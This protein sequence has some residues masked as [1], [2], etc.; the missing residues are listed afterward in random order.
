MKRFVN[1]IVQSTSAIIVCLLLLLSSCVDDMFIPNDN[2]VPE[3]YVRL[4]F[5][6]HVSDMKRV[7]TRSVDPDGVDIQSLTLFCFNPYGLFITTVD[8][9]IT[10]DGPTEG[11]FQADI[12]EETHII[13]F[14][15]NQNSNLF[16]NKDFLNKNEEAVMADME[17]ASGMLIYWA[18]IVKNGEQSFNDQISAMPKGVELIRNQAMIKIDDWTTPYFTV[19]GYVTTNIH[20]FGTV[21]PHHP[22]DGFVWPGNEPF[23]TLP[24]NPIMMSDIEDI[25]TKPEDYVFEHENTI[26]NPISVIIKGRNQGTYEDLYYR[27]SLIDSEGD[28]IMIRRNHAYTLHITGKLS[29][30]SKTFEEALSAPFSNNIWI[31]IDSWVT[32]IEDEKYR[33]SVSTTGV[34]LDAERAGSKYTLHYTLKRIDGGTLSQADKPDVSWLGSNNVAA[35]NFTHNFDTSTG[36]GEIIINLNPLHNDIQEGMLLIKKGKLQRTIE[37]N[38]IKPQK[39]IPSWVGTQIYG[40]VTGE[41]VTLKFTIPESCPDILYPFP[42]LISVNTLDVRASSGMTLPVIRKGEDGWFGEDYPGIE[43]KYEYIVTKPGPQRIYFKNILTFNEGTTENITIEAKHF[44]S[45]TK[46]FSFTNHQHAIMTDGLNEFHPTG[47]DGEFAQDE[48]IYYALVPQKKNALITFNLKLI[49]KDTGQSIN[50][51]PNDEFLLYSKTLDYLQ[52]GE[53]GSANVNQFDCI[54]YPVDEEYWNTSSNGRVMMFMPRNHIAAKTGHYNIYLRTN[55]PRGTDIVRISSNQPNSLSAHPDKKGQDYIGNSYRSS[56]FEL[57]TY[58]PFRF[59]ARI[60]GMGTSKSDREEEIVDDIELTYLPNQSVEV[61]FEITSFLGID[62][63]SVDPFGEEFEVY[64]DAP[65]LDIDYDRLAEFN[66]TPNKLYPH[67]TIAGRYVYKVAA[68]REEERRYGS[69]DIIVT[70]ATGANQ[71]G[72][73]KHLP[74]ITKRVTTAGNIRI[75]ADEDMV[76]F[77]NKTF[78]LSNRPITGRISYRGTDNIEHFVPANSFVVFARTSDGVRIGSIMITSD[79]RYSLNLRSE[80]TFSWN[81]DEVEFNYTDSNGVV[82][83]CQINSLADL[84]DSPNVVLTPAN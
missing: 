51:G 66:L 40:G 58:H 25:N 71:R 21:A 55:T 46:T 82:Y 74:F 33:M 72:E 16:N 35:H 12:P 52:D 1:N 81:L 76:V 36:N 19:T 47:Y 79:G 84:F 63:K 23:I 68:S 30:G 17:G 54:F 15:A 44:E 57:Q 41:F 7:D 42:V 2:D 56:I 34:V 61:S 39:F 18:R 4:Q 50:A 38:V 13:H 3:G 49:D 29:H 77:Y 11:R 53:E 78:K 59:A 5:T 83:D 75:S 26:D 45:L 67:P 65:M 8:A 73:R 28:Q 62:G 14:L 70:D 69:N 9:K 48:L 31:S 27:V 60:N 6:T 37:V 10:N 80:Y 64:I 43:Y 22:Q 24:I 32:E 20:A